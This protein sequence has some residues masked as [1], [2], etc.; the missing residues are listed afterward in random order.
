MDCSGFFMLHTTLCVG[1]LGKQQK[2]QPF[3]CALAHGDAACAGRA[4]GELGRTRWEWGR[5]GIPHATPLGS[6]V[7]HRLTVRRRLGGGGK[8]I[9][10]LS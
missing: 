10:L 2:L 8:W 3:P 9:V 1:I 6:R 4:A 7:P 5:V